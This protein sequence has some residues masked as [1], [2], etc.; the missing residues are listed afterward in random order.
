MDFDLAPPCEKSFL[1]PWLGH[2]V[3]ITVASAL[4]NPPLLAADVI[5]ERSL[6]S[7]EVISVAKM[8][9]T[10]IFVASSGSH[11]PHSKLFFDQGI[12]RKMA[13]E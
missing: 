2:T 5:C 7:S 9:T 4:A 8:S 10:T 1:H 13:N 6:Y 11:A 3:K 12:K